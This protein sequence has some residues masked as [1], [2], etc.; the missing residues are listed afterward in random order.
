MWD[1][2]PTTARVPL[3]GFFVPCCRSWSRGIFK[4]HERGA[5]YRGIKNPIEELSEGIKVVGFFFH[6]ILNYNYE[7]EVFEYLFHTFLA[8]QTCYFMVNTGLMHYGSIEFK[9]KS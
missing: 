6:F 9:K 7:Y 5:K 8:S 2:S 1:F 3:M 4:S